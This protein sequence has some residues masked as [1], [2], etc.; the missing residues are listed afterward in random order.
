[1]LF[2][3]SFVCVLDVVIVV[4]NQTTVKS[5]LKLFCVALS[6]AEYNPSLQP[7]R[8]GAPPTLPAELLR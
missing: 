6:N 4:R 7:I 5:I 1:M 8:Y 3:R 2:L